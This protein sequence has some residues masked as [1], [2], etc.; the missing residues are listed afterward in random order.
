M[1][2]RKMVQHYYIVGAFHIWLFLSISLSF[3]LSSK[4]HRNLL[5]LQHY[6][7]SKKFIAF[8]PV[9]FWEPIFMSLS[10]MCQPTFCPSVSWRCWL[11]YEAFKKIPPRNDPELSAQLKRNWNK[12]LSKQFLKTVSFQFHFN[13]A[14]GVTN[15]FGRNVKPH[16]L[17]C[18]PPASSNILFHCLQPAKKKGV[19]IT[20][21]RRWPLTRLSAS[22]FGVRAACFIYK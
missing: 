8:F 16:S 22:G 19:G 20:S 4:C 13:C 10:L 5:H 15:V 9:L 11:G 1:V 21:I 3:G 14:D 7:L 18:L 6:I 2:C 12:T 17:S